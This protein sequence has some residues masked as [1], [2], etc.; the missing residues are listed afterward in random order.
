MFDSLEGN[1]MCLGG[2]R[3]KK[4]EDARKEAKSEAVCSH[5]NGLHEI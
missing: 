3:E 1:C 5:R 4:E 2:E